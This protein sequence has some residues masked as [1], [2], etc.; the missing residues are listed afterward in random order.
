VRSISDS[1]V[2]VVLGPLGLLSGAFGCSSPAPAHTYTVRD[3]S[4]V[5]VVE[6]QGPAWSS[7]IGWWLSTEPSLQIG[8]REGEEPFQF[9]DVAGGLQ[10]SDGR[11]V[12]LNAGTQ[13]VRV[14]SEQ[15]EF[16]TEFGGA[17][18]GPGEF[19]RL[20]SVHQ[21]AGDTVLVWDPGRPGF[22]LFTASGAFLGSTTLM[23]PGSEQ[24]SSV[25][26]LP[27]GRL[28]VS[29]YASPATQGGDRGVGIHRDMAPILVFDREGSLVDTL[30]VYPSAE[31]MIMRLGRDTGLGTAPFAKSTLLAVSGSTVH[32]GTADRMELSVLD[33]DGALEA[34]FRYPGVEL[35]LK[36]EDREWFRARLSEMV[37]TPEEQQILGAMLSGLV[38]PDT[39]AAFSDLAVDPGGAIWLRTGRHFPPMG[40]SAEW[41]VFSA[42]GFLL[43]A[44]Q[45]P[46]RFEPLE[47]GVDQVMGVWKDEF[48]VE[49]VRI[50]PILGRG[51]E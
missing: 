41:T 27:D 34:V 38:F 43:G 39:R 12:I 13:T 4:G 1:P 36:E 22:S 14:F 26:P 9:F 49:F 8:K 50:Y 10:L 31:T 48:D 18:R 46:E 19:R 30:G 42:D 28:L 32:L 23:P 29:T 51:L 40:P 5:T 47:F 7:G 37:S 11:I 35:A 21:L 20:R 25:H 6:S 44:V 15:G 16:L 45:F 17:G 24:L 3:S 2:W 33:L